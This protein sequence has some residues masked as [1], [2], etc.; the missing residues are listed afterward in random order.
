[1][2][3]GRLI[4]T[5]GDQVFVSFGNFFVGVVVGRALGPADF[6]IFTLLWSTVLFFNVLQQSFI[7]A[8]M[9]S[10]RVRFSGRGCQE[11]LG[12]VLKLQFVFAAAAALLITGGFFVATNIGWLDSGYVRY[13]W[14]LSVACFFYQLQEC[15]R[16]MLQGCGQHFAALLSDLSCYGLQ[17]LLLGAALLTKH[18]TTDS[19]LWTLTATWALGSAFLFGLRS[20][21]TIKRASIRRAQR[22]HSPF[23][24]SLAVSNLFQWLSAYGAL[25]AV[26][27]SLS[28]LDVGNIRAA[29]NLI[30]PLNVLS[31]GLQTYLAIEA[32]ELYKKEGIEAVSK[33]LR[34]TILR[35]IGISVPISTVFVL[36]GDPLMKAVLGP[37]FSINRYWLL[38]QFL[39]VVAGA[40]FGFLAV[41]FKTLDCTQYAAVAAGLGFIVAI[42][43]VKVLL[44]VMA[45]GAVFAALLGSQVVTALVAG[46]Y[47]RISPAAVEQVSC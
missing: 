39:S 27:A 30:A 35:F 10:L 9:L 38:I 45:A 17:I 44:P 28:V 25:Y 14:P 13:A 26:G 19:T 29:M 18:L 37:R 11:Y 6:G 15:V 31:V 32:A 3:F 33:L 20:S 24:V 2:K 43:A 8:P 22:T 36:L 7:I 1:M 4:L 42:V 47:A 34:T 40:T 16:R 46:Y 21:C 41:R 12:D 23:G 5:T